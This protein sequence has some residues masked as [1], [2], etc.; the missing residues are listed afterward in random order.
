MVEQTPASR[1]TRSPGSQECVGGSGAPTIAGQHLGDFRQRECA[2]REAGGGLTER[3]HDETLA[4]GVA[5]RRIASRSFVCSM[6]PRG[7]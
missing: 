2:A 7:A 3:A 5:V 1:A 4:E 6:R